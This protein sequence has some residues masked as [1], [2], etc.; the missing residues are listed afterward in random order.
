[1]H[2]HFGNFTDPFT[3]DDANTVETQ[4]A[5]NDYAV[6][7]IAQTVAQCPGDIL[8]AAGLERSGKQLNA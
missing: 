6:D 5:D 3:L 1:M 4:I 8:S 7:L 2:D